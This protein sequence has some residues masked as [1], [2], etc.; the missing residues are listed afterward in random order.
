MLVLVLHSWPS[1]KF[2][3]AGE[4]KKRLVDDFD[5]AVTPLVFDLS[6]KVDPSSLAGEGG[7]KILHVYGSPNPNDTALT[8][9]GTIMNVC[10]APLFP[11][12]AF[13]AFARLGG[14]ACTPC[15]CLSQ[16]RTPK[17][18]ASCMWPFSCIC[19]L[20]GMCRQGTRQ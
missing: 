16:G 13:K 15:L 11:S 18:L 10:K 3:I 12:P 5:F 14:Q 17:C 20:A 8:G 7:W 1:V 2:P 9:N 6:L 4:F 19:A